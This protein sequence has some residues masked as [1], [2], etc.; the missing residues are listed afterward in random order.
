VGGAVVL[1]GGYRWVVRLVIWA[2]CL[3]VLGVAEGERGLQVVP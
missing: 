1:W 2:T 3:V